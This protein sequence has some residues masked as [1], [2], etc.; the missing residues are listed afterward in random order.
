MARRRHNAATHA[1]HPPH[2]TTAHHYAQRGHL[3][4]RAC[5]W[6]AAHRVLAE[7]PWQA[8]SAV[9]RYGCGERAVRLTRR[10]KVI[11]TTCPSTKATGAGSVR[12]CKLLFARKRSPPL[13]L[14]L[15]TNC[16]SRGRPDDSGGAAAGRPAVLAC[17]NGRPVDDETQRKLTERSGKTADAGRPRFPASLIQ[18]SSIIAPSPLWPRR[19]DR[20]RFT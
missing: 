13:L 1:S 6:R 19:M 17:A 5:W 8:S 10:R 12:S 9:S 11:P 7:T 16:R 20:V 14:L 18:A 3:A 2:P 15:A 4:A